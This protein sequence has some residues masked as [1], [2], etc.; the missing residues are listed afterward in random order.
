MQGLSSQQVW[1]YDFWS[2]TPTKKELE[3]G[4]TS[5]ELSGKLRRCVSARCSSSEDLHERLLSAE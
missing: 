3:T 1:A 4:R 2:I 5:Y